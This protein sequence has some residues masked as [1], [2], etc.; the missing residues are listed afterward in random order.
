MHKLL[1]T[2][3]IPLLISSAIAMEFADKADNSLHSSRAAT[4][5]NEEDGS[6]ANDFFLC[7]LLKPC[8]TKLMMQQ[9]LP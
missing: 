5:V 8:S 1:Y 3:A 2:A 9:L 4:P 6:Q 7:L